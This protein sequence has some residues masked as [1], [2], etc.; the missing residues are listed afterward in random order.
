ME[1]E[2]NG[3]EKHVV[4]S[5]PSSRD[6]WDPAIS[7][8]LDYVN[9]SIAFLFSPFFFWLELGFCQPY[10]LPHQRTKKKKKKNFNQKQN[11]INT[12]YLQHSVSASSVSIDSTEL[13]PK[14][15]RGKKTQNLKISKSKIWICC[16]VATI[17]IALT[18]YL[19]SIMYYSYIEKIWSIERMCIVSTTL[20]YIRDLNIG[21]F[22]YPQ[23]VLEPIF[24]R[25]WDD[26]SLLNKPQ[27]YGITW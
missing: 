25:Y 20:S 3:R 26:Y 5:L 22:W 23:G 18:L 12:P 11:I 14:I 1:R 19:H 24:L 17:Y 6:L 7:S 4:K 13:G 8:W 16:K 21:R 2:P 27:L 10:P 15:F 9:W